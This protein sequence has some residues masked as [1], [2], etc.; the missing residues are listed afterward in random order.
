M[1]ADFLA[2]KNCV[3]VSRKVETPDG[4][5]GE[6]TSTTLTTLPKAVIWSPSQSR[7]YISD[8]MARVSSHVL[9]TI[10]SDYTFT[11]QDSE[12]IYN[13]KTYRITGPSDDVME[14]GEIMMTGLER[15]S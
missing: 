10:P 9:V 6:S 4:M 1:L 13:G 15:M 14:L 11:D 8:K 7:S 12:V 5:G 2:L 3:Q